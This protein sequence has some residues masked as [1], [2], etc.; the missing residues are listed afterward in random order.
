MGDLSQSIN[1]VFEAIVE[2][3]YEDEH[4]TVARQMLLQPHLRLARIAKR[5]HGERSEIGLRIGR[6][7]CRPL[8][9]TDLPVIGRRDR[10]GDFGQCDLAFALPGEQHARIARWRARR[11]DE[12]IDAR[13]IGRARRD[14]LQNASRPAAAGEKAAGQNKSRRAHR[15]LVLIDA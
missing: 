8:H 5:D 2:A 1:G 6:Q 10:H 15:F 3:M 13:G 12:K 14:W 7:A 9:L 4:A 11:R